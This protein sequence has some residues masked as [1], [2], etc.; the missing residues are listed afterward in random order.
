M[1]YVG[2]NCISV[3][4]TLLCCQD[5]EEVRYLLFLKVDTK[6]H[7]VGRGEVEGEKEEKQGKVRIRRGCQ[8]DRGEG[9]YWTQRDF[10][11]CAHTWAAGFGEWGEG[12]RMY[13]NF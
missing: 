11:G 3:D 5:E 6:R 4:M 7:I 12:L 8:R 10:T 1:H 2:V 13:S 9:R